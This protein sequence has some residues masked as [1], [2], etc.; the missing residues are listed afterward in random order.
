MGV[1]IHA[2]IYFSFTV[3]C[4][5]VCSTGVGVGASDGAGAGSGAGALRQ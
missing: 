2:N 5:I 3:P 1:G 4:M